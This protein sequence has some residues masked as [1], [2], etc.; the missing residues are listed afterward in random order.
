M[1][2]QSQVCRD[3]SCCL[4]MFPIKSILKP[5]RSTELEEYILAGGTFFNK[6]FRN[7][8]THMGVICGNGPQLGQN[9]SRSAIG[10]DISPVL[11]SVPC[12]ADQ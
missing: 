12:R 6:S 8:H 2:N 3:V 7:Y 11:D 1:L 5:S 9:G 10:L 4:V